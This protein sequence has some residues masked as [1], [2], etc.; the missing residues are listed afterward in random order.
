MDQQKN[1]KDDLPGKENYS[2]VVI[3]AG[4]GGIGMGCQLRTKLGLQSGQMLIV[5]RQSA[6]GGTWWINKYPGVQCDV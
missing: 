6:V 4:F 3:G 2:V 5:E 1:L